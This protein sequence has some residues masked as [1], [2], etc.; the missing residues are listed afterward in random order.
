[1]KKLIVNRESLKLQPLRQLIAKQKRRTL[2]LWVI[3]CAHSVLPIFESE[4]PN[5]NRPRNA[6]EA[7][8][9]WAQGK[10]KMSIAKKAA[11]ATHNA[12]TLISDENPAACAAA[13]AIGHVV[14][15]VH[16]E[17]H[18]MSF[19]LYTLTAFV[20]ATNQNSDDKVI[21]ERCNWL[22]DRLLYWETNIEK[23]DT[24]WASF[25]LKDN[26]PNKE[27][28]LMEKEQKERK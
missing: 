12:A 14:G 18:A 5:D 16:V 3:D 7:A 17:T 1:M 28:L 22:Y 8:K 9:K 24:P 15:T 2:V 27:A 11:L 4:Y 6:I 13:R 25:L 20:Y 10:I 23:I 26:L 21:T 19:V